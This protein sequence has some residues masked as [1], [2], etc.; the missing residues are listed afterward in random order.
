MITI[1]NTNNKTIHTEKSQLEKSQKKVRT[2]Q[3]AIKLRRP[4]TQ[5]EIEIS[6]KIFE[7]SID[8]SKV[9]IIRSMKLSV[10]G[11]TKNSFSP[12]GNIHITSELFDEIPDFSNYIKDFSAEHHFIHEMTH[13]WQYQLNSSK[14]IFN[15]AK[16]LFKGGYICSKF[17]PDYNR[18]DYT[19]YF[20]DL[21]ET[22]SERKFNE[23]NLEQQGRIIEYWYDAVYMQSK[24]PKRNHH[25][26]SIKLL[27]FVERVL[28]DF[29]LNPYD[30]N[31]LPTSAKID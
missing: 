21:S 15:A 26:Q 31:H 20:T 9:F 28:R 17:S 27:G 24:L 7:Y 23:F 14:H 1:M 29:L 4:L 13:I 10:S 6:R 5:G 18:E 25:M 16:I 2:G 11:L 8:Y 12:L 22:H 3:V 19:A 30:K